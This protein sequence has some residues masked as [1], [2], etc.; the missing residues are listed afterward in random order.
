MVSLWQEEKENK[1]KFEE[2]LA[3]MRREMFKFKYPYWSEIYGSKTERHK[4]KKLDE[5]VMMFIEVETTLFRRHLEKEMLNFG[6]QEKR[7]IVWQYVD[8]S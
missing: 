8:N 7:G 5:M 6:N 1:K 4:E 3:L 2:E